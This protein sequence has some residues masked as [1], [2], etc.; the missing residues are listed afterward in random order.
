MRPTYVAV[1]AGGS[2]GHI[3]PGI[4]LARARALQ[5]QDCHVML[6]ATGR[7]FDQAIRTAHG[8]DIKVVQLALGDAPKSVGAYPLFC[9]QLAWSFMQSFVQL[10][11]CRP[12]ELI[13][14]GGYISIPVCLA[15]WCLR[16][17]RTVY[18]LNAV[19]GKATRFL[20]P[21]ASTIHVC[22]QAAAKYFPAKKTRVVDYPIRFKKP[23]CSPE[24]AKKAL[25][26]PL[27]KK[28][29]LILGGSQGSTFLNSAFLSC[30]RTHQDLQK[31]LSVIHQTG[32]TTADYQTAYD[33]LS[34]PARVFDYHHDLSLHY[35]AAD[36]IMCRAGAGTIFEAL[37]FEKTCILVP[38]EIPGNDHQV[39]NAQAICA[40]YPEHCVCIRQRQLADS[41]ELLAQALRK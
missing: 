24:E 22:F 3:T 6:F 33:Q 41:T 18:E 2:G 40:A 1:V 30:V 34:V 14:M 37:F 38:L 29:I 5:F 27:D 16:I 25:G 7:S 11:R 39:H 9:A 26:L 10:I 28:T 8:D 4:T 19:P 36:I 13:V 17:P 23:T 35:Q 31:H 21:F 12:R 15:A 32:K 20:A